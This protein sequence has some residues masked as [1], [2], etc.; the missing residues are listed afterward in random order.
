MLTLRKILDDV[1]LVGGV[2]Y[3]L[4]NRCWMLFSTPVTMWL[5]LEFLDPVQQGYYYTFLGILAY[6]ALAEFGFNAGLIHFLAIEWSN[7]MLLDGRVTGPSTS[8]KNLSTLLK[9]A[10]NW[11]IF[12]SSLAGV[13]FYLIG[14]FF[15]SQKEGGSQIWF[16][17][18][19]FACLAIIFGLSFQVLKSVAEGVDSVHQSQQAS[20]FGA[21][22]SAILVWMGLLYGLGLYVIPLAIISNACVG[23]L[24][25]AYAIK[26]ILK[27]INYNSKECREINWAADFFPH[28]A[29]LGL[30]LIFGLAMFQSFIPIIFKFQGAIQVGQVG[31]LLQA[32]VLI[33]SISM[34]WVSNA[35]PN[36]GRCWALGDCDGVIK[37][38]HEVLEK[39]LFTAT[40]FS[41]LAVCFV[42]VIKMFWPEIG[43]RIGSIS[44]L[45]LLCMTVVV[46]QFSNVYTAAI[47]YRK[48]ESFLLVAAT[49]AV[50]VVVSNLMLVKYGTEAVFLGFFCIMAFL[51]NPWIYWIYK[52]QMS[53][54]L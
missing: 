42:Y 8:L 25:L 29:K 51:V 40:L 32:Y 47:R 33:N 31:I 19:L 22:F 4:L 28:Q 39:S 49:G 53:E 2:Q 45:L 35:G 30:S 9:I 3:Y 13:I 54:C 18:W 24:Y 38:V 34:V 5:V 41:G 14:F 26:P 52:K 21:V 7:L 44:A 15:F 50:L 36:F 10:I 1:L 27:C 48:K 17:P 43:G 20:L 23:F 12:S 37:I 16:Y 6:Q 46:M 11:A